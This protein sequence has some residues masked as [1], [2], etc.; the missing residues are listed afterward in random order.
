[1]T[2]ISCV[3]LIEAHKDFFV[4]M[5]AFLSPFAAVLIG[6]IS[7]RWQ[8]SALLKSTSMQIR[9]SALR[10]YRQ[11]NIE[12]LREEIASEIFYIADLRLK[13]QEIGLHDARAQQ[14]VFDAMAR[15]IR[16]RVLQSAASSEELREAFH[17]EE[18]LIDHIRK[19]PSE[20]VWSDSDNLAIQQKVETLGNLYLKFLEKEMHAVSQEAS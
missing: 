1:M 13:Q 4:A 15:K 18:Q 7:S 5:G 17:F 10:D 19:R 14:L 11:R 6:L 9:A 2:I 20:T 8:A 16:I 3:R 12:K